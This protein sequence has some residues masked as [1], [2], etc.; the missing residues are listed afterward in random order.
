MFF[1]H[2]HAI[3]DTLKY[4]RAM[5]MCM[6]QEDIVYG[7]CMY[8]RN[9]FSR[10]FRRFR[11]AT[12]GSNISLPTHCTSQIWCWKYFCPNILWIAMLWKGEACDGYFTIYNELNEMYIF[13]GK[14]CYFK[15]TKPRSTIRP[16][17]RFMFLHIIIAK[18]LV[19][20][21][22]TEFQNCRSYSKKNAYVYLNMS[23]FIFNINI[24]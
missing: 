8:W 3:Q 20:E 5:V 10:R 13:A 7:T 11:V 23:S 21:M 12:N 14:H 18:G 9:M 4:V 17:F 22:S 24:W 1:R 6:H 15:R 2:P 19:T 16:L